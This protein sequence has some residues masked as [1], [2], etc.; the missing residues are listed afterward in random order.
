M[1]FKGRGNKDVTDSIKR[2]FRKIDSTPARLAFDA[3]FF[4]VSPL[5][6]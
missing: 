3:I 2:S 1:V 5:S 4:L 6:G